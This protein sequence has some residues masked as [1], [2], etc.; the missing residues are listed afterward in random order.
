MHCEVAINGGRQV[1]RKVQSAAPNA[2]LPHPAAATPS[3]A[4][5]STQGC[6][7]PM[8]GRAKTSARTAAAAG[9]GSAAAVVACRRCLRGSCRHEGVAHRVCGLPES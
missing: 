7:S 2:P 4:A 8:P 3:P 9:G 6:S 1:A 5:G